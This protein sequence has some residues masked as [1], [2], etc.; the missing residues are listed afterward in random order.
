[1][2]LLVLVEVVMRFGFN[3]GFLWVQELTLH[4]SAWLVLFGAS[5]GI[6][7]GAHIGVDSVV[8]MIPS[9]TRRWV[10]MAAVGLSLIYCGLF[11]YGGWIYL[12]KM[13]KIGIELE[14]LPIPR[15]IAHSVLFIGFF[16]L[17]LRLIQ[18]LAALA[19]RP[20]ERLPTGR[21]GGGGAPGGGGGRRRR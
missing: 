15:W 11:M 8:K 9:G 6:K 19:S 17:A 21:R 7:V 12:A 1:M 14:D 10:S 5:Y 20:G 3:T 4:A 16:L 18:L 13:L 2:T